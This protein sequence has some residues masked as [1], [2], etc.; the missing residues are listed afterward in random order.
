MGW[1]AGHL[2]NIAE[3]KRVLLALCKKELTHMSHKNTLVHLA[4]P[5]QKIAYVI[6]VVIAAST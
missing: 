4:G 1:C 5:S 2:I 3:P 6:L